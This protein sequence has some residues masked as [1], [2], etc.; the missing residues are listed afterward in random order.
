MSLGCFKALPCIH[1]SRSEQRQIQRKY[2]PY[3][4]TLRLFLT[5]TARR[6]PRVIVQI[7]TGRKLAL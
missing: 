4:R 2:K 6:E 5:E 3:T 7:Q 1:S